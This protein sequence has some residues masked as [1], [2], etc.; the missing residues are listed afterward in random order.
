MVQKLYTYITNATFIKFCLVGTLN[1]LIDVGILQL[2]LLVSGIDPHTSPL[3][4]VFVLIAFFS[5]VLNGFFL[6]K[7]WTFRMRTRKNST[8]QFIKFLI[9]N[10]VGLGLTMILM[11]FLVQLL[12]MVP[13]IAKLCTSALVLVWNF[14]ATKHW[15]FKERRLA[16]GLTAPSG[17]EILLS[18]VIPAYNEATRIE[19]TLTEVVGYLKGK[20]FAFEL[21]VV[22]DGSRDG[23]I[24]VVER[25]IAAHDLS[26]RACVL[27][28]GVNRGKG[29]AVRTGV[30]RATG[31]YVLFTDADNSTPIH[32]V[33]RFL[34]E[35]EEVDILIGSRYLAASKVEKKQPW[36]RIV[37]SR[38]ANFVITI[39]LIDG[40]RDTQCGFKM[41]KYAAAKDIFSRMCVDGFGFDMELLALAEVLDYRVKELPVSWFDSPNSRVQPVRAALRTLGD[42]ATIKMG[43]WT[44][45]YHLPTATEGGA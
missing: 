36:H 31:E 1:T 28:L 17:R 9:T 16:K 33:D 20:S 24:A 11:F 39:F 6:N 12:H 3:L 5:A 18:I 13:Y 42:L 22:D 30:L 4:F 34:D 41:L 8:R 14:F 23:T 27:P 25:F 37:L 43:I 45:K 44:G 2:L 26:D 10:L 15:T 35:I 38:L 32:E 19:E 21:L 7:L 40:I 29:A